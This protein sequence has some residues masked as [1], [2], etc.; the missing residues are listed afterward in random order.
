MPEDKYRVLKK[1]FGHDSF[2]EGQETAVNALLSG[3]DVVCIMSTGAGKSL[4]YQVPAMMLEGTAVVVSPLI[5]LMKDQV[6]SL[7]EAGISAAYLNSSLTP[8]EYSRTLWALSSGEIKILY[9]APERLEAVDFRTVI[10]RIRVSMI[11]ID[12]AHCV[13]M[14]GQDF[15][16]SFL[17][18]SDFI[19]SFRERPVIGAFTATATKS[20][21]SDIVRYLGLINPVSIITPFDRPNLFFSV[22]T[23]ASKYN[24]LIRLLKERPDQSGIV[25]CST[26]RAVDEVCEFLQSQGFSAS[27]YHAGLED[28]E[29]RINQDDFVFERSL[30]M[31]ATNAFGMGIDKSNVRFVIHFNMP[32]SL[33]SYFQEAGRAGRDGLPSDCILLFSPQDIRVAQYLINNADENTELSP[34]Q[35]RE[36]KRLD[37]ERLKH[38][39]FYCRTSGCLRAHILKYFG[40]DPPP[41]CG[42]CSNC[43][44]TFAEE[45][46]TVEAMKIL[47]CIVRAD[48]RFGEKFISDILRGSG[49]SKILS[50]GLDRLSTYGIMSGFTEKRIRSIIAF[51]ETEGVVVKVGA[52]YPVLKLTKEALPI[53]RGQRKVVMKVL[54]DELPRRGVTEIGISEKVLKR[55]ESDEFSQDL[56]KELKALR[57]EKANRENVPAYIIFSDAALADMC[58]KLPTN[59]EEFLNVSGVGKRKLEQYGDDFIEVIKNFLIKE[60]KKDG[61]DVSEDIPE[62]DKPN[63][64]APKTYADDE[65]FQ[66]PEKIGRPEFS[67]TE[68][69]LSG[70]RFSDQPLTLSEI[71]ARLNELCGIENAKKLHNRAALYFLQD[72][73][74]LQPMINPLGIEVLRPTMLGEELGI[75]KKILTDDSGAYTVVTYSR[76]AQEYIVQ[77]IGDIA[78]LNTKRPWLNKE[79][80][81]DE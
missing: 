5:S 72:E 34:E 73:N 18:I 41:A 67:L 81:Q 7:K 24:E 69:E 54:K 64:A 19:A 4:C 63:T 47:S 16:P 8:E 26:R 36:V 53:L 3:R 42:H 32:K 74:L 57:R 56:I 43:I 27:K 48:Q 21:R 61:Q 70:F 50:L 49:S 6:S 46:V 65:Y 20:V 44:A 22:K 10:S 45:D 29:R 59:R 11:A 78:D 12:E 51:L 30:I 60:E 1:Y 62:H 77:S 38:M 39:I 75:K 52:E 76:T 68:E 2:R 79:S 15:R 40:E 33:E 37:S 35:L 58:K 66:R 71:V 31:V 14:W 9:A 25:Y 23:P 17:K 28:G 55:A 13:S 80:N